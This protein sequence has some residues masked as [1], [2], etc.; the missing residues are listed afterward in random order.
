MRSI[1]ISA[2]ALALILPLTVHSTP[3]PHPKTGAA[4]PLEINH[5]PAGDVE[6]QM[7]KAEKQSDAPWHLAEFTRPKEDDDDTEK[8][9]NNY[10]YRRLPGTIVML[11]VITSEPDFGGRA[12]ILSTFGIVNLSTEATCAGK[13][14]VGKQFGIAK[15]ATL[16]TITVKDNV[17]HT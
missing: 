16:R 6:Q 17:H 2:Y 10:Y 14:A 8:S 7:P 13:F 1:F 4:Q 9:Q 5:Q 11:G 15:G 3:I 12:E